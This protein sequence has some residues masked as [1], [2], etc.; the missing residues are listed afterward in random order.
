[1][2]GGRWGDGFLLSLFLSF[3]FLFFFFFFRLLGFMPCLDYY[4]VGPGNVHRKVSTLLT[5]WF[6]NSV[7]IIVIIIIIII[8][9]DPLHDPRRNLHHSVPILHFL[10]R[11]YPAATPALALQLLLVPLQAPDEGALH[12]YLV[13]VAVEDDGDGDDGDLDEAQEGSGPV[14]VEFRV[15]LRFKVRVSIDS[16]WAPRFKAVR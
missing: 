1:M 4:F 13:S 8:I 10:L 3:Y 12:A 7:I 9:V 11:P 2:V 16:L 6:K 15:H 5:P 14:G